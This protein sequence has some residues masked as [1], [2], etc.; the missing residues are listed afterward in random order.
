MTNLPVKS[1][2]RAMAVQWRMQACGGFED[3]A[4]RV[5]YFAAVAGDYA[6]DFLCFPEFM[7][8]ELLS[9]APVRLDAAAAMQS[10]AAHAPALDALFAELARVHRVNIVGGAFPRALADDA[11]RNVAT[12][13]HRDGRVDRRCKIHVTP[14]EREVWG[15]A[16]GDD[17]AVIESDCGPV[18]IA[19]C[20]DSEF[21]EQVRHLA[22][23]GAQI[24][25][26][27]FCTDERQGYLRVRHACAARCI[28]NQVYAVLA[29]TVGHLPR[30]LNMDIQYAQSCILTPCDAA[31]FARDGIAAEATPDSECVVFADLDLALLQQA[32]ERGTVRNL[33]DRRPD[34]YELWRR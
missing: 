32:R 4:A 14:S 28:E 9:A 26:V 34:L 30:V 31:F 11:V 33:G 29:G 19:I 22:L 21:P 25:F 10:M 5:R 20:Y 27:P 16:G 23:S 6:C 17:A 7:P 2:V 13:Y 1:R 8:L 18:G 15:V 24:L 12:L 3:F